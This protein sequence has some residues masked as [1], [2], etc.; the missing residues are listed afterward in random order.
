VTNLVDNAVRHNE[1]GG[2]VRVRT[3]RQNGSCLLSVANG[4][5][6]I[7]AGSLPELTEP[8]RRL[9]G[10]IGAAGPAGPTGSDGPAGLVGSDADCGLGL[11]IVASVVSAHSG[12]LELRAPAGGGLEVDVLLP[13]APDPPAVPAPSA[14][15]TPL[16]TAA[17]PVAAS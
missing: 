14:T 4:G 3:T 8:F 7:P 5:A 16:A 2:W 12:T 15:R 6:V 11:S 10:R 17:D 13:A 1:A 9:A